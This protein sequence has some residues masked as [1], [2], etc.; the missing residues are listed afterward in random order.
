MS[1]KYRS[2]TLGMVIAIAAGQMAWAQGPKITP[3]SRENERRSFAV[4]VLKAINAAEADYKAKNQRYGNWDALVGNGYFGESGTK[5]S[6]EEFPTVAHAMY[7][8]GAEIAPG[9]RLRLNI[10]NGGKSYDA[11]LEDVTDPKCGFAALTD[12]RGRVRVA[13][14]AECTM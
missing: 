7:G 13:K 4:N 10:S 9:W 5:W 14:A 8:S 12:E 6:S 1:G 11:L 3:A 2:L